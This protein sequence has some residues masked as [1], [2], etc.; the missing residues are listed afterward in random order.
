MDKCFCH[1]KDKKTG[2]IFV[3]K[4]K[5]ARQQIENLNKKVEEDISTALQDVSSEIEDLRLEIIGELEGDY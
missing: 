2:E 1:I 3:V 4:D 5:E